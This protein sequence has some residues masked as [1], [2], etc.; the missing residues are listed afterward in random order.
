MRRGRCA[1]IYDPNTIT[2]ESKRIFHDQLVIFSR[3]APASAPGVL[4]ETLKRRSLF[5]LLAVLFRATQR[6]TLAPSRP[7]HHS[8]SA[9]GGSMI[10]RR[11]LFAVAILSAVTTL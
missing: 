1:V 4:P 11:S 6:Y 9:F 2:D 3:P 8:C 5:C 7:S 10:F